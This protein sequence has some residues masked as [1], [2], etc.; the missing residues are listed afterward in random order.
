MLL[1]KEVLAPLISQRGLVLNV[2]QPI[3]ATAGRFLGLEN[4]K[5]GSFCRS[6]RSSEI[7]ATAKLS[8]QGIGQG[9]R[10][11]VHAMPM[12]G[13]PTTDEQGMGEGVWNRAKK[14]TTFDNAPQAACFIALASRLIACS[15]ERCPS[16]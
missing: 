1:T 6:K 2:L 4:G 15:S 3:G 11:S 8:T 16:Q 9:H 13:A 10:R 5:G 14:T 7:W 12:W